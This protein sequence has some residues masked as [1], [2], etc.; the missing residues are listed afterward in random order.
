MLLDYLRQNETHRGRRV[1]G[2]DKTRR[3]R[4]QKSCSNDTTDLH[5]TE[6]HATMRKGGRAVSNEAVQSP[7]TPIKVLSGC[8]KSLLRHSLESSEGGEVFISREVM[9]GNGK[10]LWFTGARGADLRLR[11]CWR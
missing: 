2:T 10:V 11:S 8:S 4:Y 3:G 9:S 7:G 5:A 6:Y 1:E